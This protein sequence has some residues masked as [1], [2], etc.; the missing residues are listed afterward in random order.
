MA[1]FE[2]LFKRR[3]FLPLYERLWQAVSPHLAITA[4]PDDPTAHRLACFHYASVIYAC[5]F[6]AALAAGMSTSTAF[7]LARIH[8]RKCPFDS[9]LAGAVDGIFSAEEGSRERRYA[10]TLQATLGRIAAA[11]AGPE[12]AAATAVKE[13]LEELERVFAALDFA[14]EGPYPPD[15]PILE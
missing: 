14:A 11:I 9:D 1:L 13:E 3:R 4:G 6:Q 15:Q 12:G 10:E 2:V 7:S 5:V 8:L